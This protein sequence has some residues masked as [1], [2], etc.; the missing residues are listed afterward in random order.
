MVFI[1]PDDFFALQEFQQLLPA[2]FG[3]SRFHEE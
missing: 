2:D 3:A 1:S